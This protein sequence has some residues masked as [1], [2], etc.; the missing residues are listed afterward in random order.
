M[1]VAYCKLA[2]SVCITVAPWGVRERTCLEEQMGTS[3]F[4]DEQVH[5]FILGLPVVA[6]R[7]IQYP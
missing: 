1:E 3:F 5:K 7:V 4:K 2:R 6:Q